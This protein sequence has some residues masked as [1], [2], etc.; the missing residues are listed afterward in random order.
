MDQLLPALLIFSLRIGD[1]SIGTLRMLYALRG[2][3]F[4]A[5]GLGLLESGI[6]I[7][8]ISR[9][10]GS[11]S[12]NP[13]NMVGYAC[14]F[15][16]GTLVGMTVENWI[17]S[18]SIIVRVISKK[19][20]GEVREALWAHGFGL[21]AVEGHGKSLP[22]YLLFIVA[23]RR[24]GKELL[25][26]VADTDPEAFVTVESVNIAHG[27]YVPHVAGPACVRM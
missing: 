15:A 20:S 18:G 27:G 1:V 23:P 16:T 13:W 11:I 10:L 6:F 25:R 12:E 21:T 7:F 22:V 3:R 24:R 17:A 9:A 26:V 8:A 2:R 5:A 14:G 4:V 19:R